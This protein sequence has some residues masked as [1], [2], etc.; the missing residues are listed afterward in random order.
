MSVIHWCKEVGR[1]VEDEISLALLQLVVLFRFSFVFSFVSRRPRSHFCVFLYFSYHGRF[2]FCFI[3]PSRSRTNSDND[4]NLVQKQ[5]TLLNVRAV[6]QLEEHWWALVRRFGLYRW[7]VKAVS[8]V[9]LRIMSL[10]MIYQ[11]FSGGSLWAEINGLPPFSKTLKQDI[12][13]KST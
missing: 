6:S 4:E 3:R 12:S 1:C 5:F 10:A 2:T 13:D 9:G 11:G 7:V 8:Y